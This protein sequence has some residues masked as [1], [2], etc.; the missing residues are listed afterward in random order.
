MSEEKD[1]IATAISNPMIAI[2]ATIS[3]METPRSEDRL[4]LLCIR[5]AKLVDDHKVVN[6]LKKLKYLADN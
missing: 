6:L 2:V 1:G 3:V 4:R 5:H